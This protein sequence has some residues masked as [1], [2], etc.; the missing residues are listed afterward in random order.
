MRPL[1]QILVFQSRQT[2]WRESAPV[3]W[4][5]SG[6]RRMLAWFLRVKRLGIGQGMSLRDRNKL[7]I[8]NFLNFFQFCTGILLP[9]L[10]FLL[11]PDIPAEAWVFAFL[12]P[13]VSL[14]ALVLNARR[15]YD[16]ALL[17]YFVLY[18][19]CTC[20][21]YINGINLGVE[22]SFVLYGI[23]S[24]FFIRDRTYMIC[25]IGFSMISY[26]V[27]AVMLKRYPFQLEQANNIAY[28]LNQ[29]IAILYI[30]YGLFLL[31]AENARFNKSLLA[32]NAAMQKQAAELQELNSLKSKLFSVISHDLKAP[33][34]ALRNLF[35]SIQ[36]QDMP[37]RE[38]KQ[39]IPEI[40]KDLNDTVGLMENLL[41]WSRSQMQADM[42]RPV[43]ID[44][45]SLMEDVL[46]VLHLQAQGKEI[47][48]KLA[49]KSQ[50]NAWVDADML[51]LVLRNLLS[52]AIKFTK[53]GGHV[54]MG[55][56]QVESGI[57]LFVLDSG[58]GIAPDV[59]AKIEAGEFHSSYGT[60]HEQGTGL[61]L[62]LCREFLSR[63][64]SQLRIDT[65]PGT[66]SRFSFRLP[67]A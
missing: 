53:P 11:T 17:V 61:G 24:V 12:P 22:L 57:E 3:N 23:L 38:I 14:I 20:L 52:N 36:A 49:I 25:S 27:L 40:K 42:A 39:M 55:A 10:F 8:F 28:L 65:I 29:A 54:E 59:L 62:L 48:V 16:T 41:Q 2:R 33:M 4:L 46:R 35:E 37:G 56:R 9:F 13:L 1:S 34:Y 18:P 19:F 21:A 45:K 44:L 6:W 26:F 58:N 66:G 50:K 47:E 32:A 63:N 31:Q 64:Q 15:Q 7:A 5:R 51:H 30:F 43:S 60:N 67:M